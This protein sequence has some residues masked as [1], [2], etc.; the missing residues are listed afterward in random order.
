MSQYILKMLA[1]GATVIAAATVGHTVVGASELRDFAELPIDYNADTLKCID[2]EDVR[3]IE[4][5]DDETIDFEIDNRRGVF[6]NALPRRCAHLFRT[7]RFNYRATRGRICEGTR[8]TVSSQ[9]RSRAV[10]CKLGEFSKVAP[11]S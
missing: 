6:R 4:V 10:Q 5:Q 8:I 7:Q 9:M 2:P 3:F 1:A 11:T